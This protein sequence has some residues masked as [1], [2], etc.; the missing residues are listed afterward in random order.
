MKKRPNN[1]GNGSSQ[2][3]MQHADMGG[4]VRFF[5]DRKNHGHP[6]LPFFLSHSLTQWF[7]QRPQLNLVAVVPMCV[8]GETVELHAWY[9]LHVFQDASGIQPKE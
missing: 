6:E 7:R 9:S 4:W 5:T 2:V 8:D 1:G 3:V